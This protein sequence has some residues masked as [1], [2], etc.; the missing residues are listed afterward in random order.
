MVYARGV[1]LEKRVRD[2]GILGGGGGDILGALPEIF[3][4]F[5][6]FQRF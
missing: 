4:I 5:E 1:S 2:F 3:G 6:D